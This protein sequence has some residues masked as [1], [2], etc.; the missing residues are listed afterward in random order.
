M[1]YGIDCG[2][3]C[4]PDTGAVGWDKEDRLTRSVGNGV[5]AALRS[6]GHEVVDCT[7]KS[8][9]SVSNSLAQ[10][11]NTAN[12]NNVDRF[13]SIHFNAF[14]KSA[15]GTEVFATSPSGRA[16]A[17]PVVREIAELG[18]FNRGVK[19]GSHLYVVKNTNAPA[20]LI[21][22]C[23]IDASKDKAIYNTDKMVSAIVRGLTGK[24]VGAIAP[25]V[26]GADKWG[27]F[28]CALRDTELEFPA[29][30]VVQL[31]QAILESG[32]GTSKLFTEHKN[33]YGMKY[34]PEMATIASKASYK[35][36]DGVDDY[37]AFKSV[38]DAV[39]GYWLFI[40]RAP[41]KGW[42]EHGASPEGYVRHLVESGYATDSKYLRKVLDVLDEARWLLS[43]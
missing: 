42:R 25:P 35:A 2:H 22:C 4:P 11:V 23:F 43:H 15:H 18:F 31:A 12:T 21:E 8:A 39:K 3:N 7:P 30:K 29:L 6:R 19:D 5:I 24:D 40:D 37:C 1:I 34:R 13:V 33:P 9:K 17:L 32:R 28:V 20:I 10:R 36:H 14:N 16:I 38:E 27:E 41:Y 26:M